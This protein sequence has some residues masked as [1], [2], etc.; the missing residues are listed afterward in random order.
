MDATTDHTSPHRP[1]SLVKRLVR[2]MRRN[3]E[4]PAT[5]SANAVR[6]DDVAPDWTPPV[7]PDVDGPQ[8]WADLDAARVPKARHAGNDPVQ[9][10]GSRAEA[11]GPPVY[12][13]PEMVNP[14]AAEKMRPLFRRER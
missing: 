5:D 12:A 2:V 10:P 7:Q 8:T 4:A 13:D 3:T 14:A 1:R 11:G 6:I 9:L